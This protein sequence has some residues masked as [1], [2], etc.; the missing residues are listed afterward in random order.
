MHDSQFLYEFLFRH[1]VQRFAGEF[2][3]KPIWFFV[4][5][6]L[7][8]GH[9]WSFLAIPYTR[10]LF[11][12]SDDAKASRPPAI[13]FLMLWSAWCFGF[14]TLSQCKLPTY[15]L[16]I[17]P[18]LSLMI[19][20]YLSHALNESSGATQHWFARFWSARSATATTCLAGVVLVVFV[21]FA[22][23]EVSFATYLWGLLWTVLLV[24][25]L[26]LLDDCHRS[27]FAWASSSAVAFLLA[28]MVMHQL[29]PT[30]A[31]ERTLFAPGT[32]LS[33]ELAME[34]QPA[35]ATVAH[36]FSEVPFYLNRS[37][38]E[39]I[40]NLDQKTVGDFVHR[41]TQSIVVLDKDT[42]FST[43]YRL[44]PQGTS[45]ELLGDRGPA[46]LLRV[47]AATPRI[48]QEQGLISQH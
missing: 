44:L 36:E 21:L 40:R 19:G 9:P 26:L 2:H 7:V 14:F 27:K 1:N 3:N 15:I 25:S 48:A 6:L 11:N 13:G 41:H 33:A 8:A 37:D 47:R 24:S 29:V 38:I 46:T 28:I 22:G 32:P 20:H 35:V 10:Y 31:R 43:F 18:P 34:K 45:V 4:P 39:N 42:P 12:R 23:F 5:V 16:P 17:A 30:Y